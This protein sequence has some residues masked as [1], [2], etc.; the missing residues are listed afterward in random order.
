MDLQSFLNLGVVGY[1]PT[2]EGDTAKPAATDLTPYYT[3]V[4][5]DAG[6]Y[7]KTASDATK[8][9]QDTAIAAK[10]PLTG[11]TITGPVS[12]QFANAYVRIK[13]TNR[14]FYIQAQDSDGSIRIVDETAG[15]EMLKLTAGQQY[16]V[17]STYVTA[18]AND[19]A[20]AYANDRVANLQYRHVTLGSVSTV[21]NQ[22]TYAP[23]GALIVGGYQQLTSNAFT[24]LR[25]VYPQV[26]DPVRGW[27]GFAQAY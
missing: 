11:G 21:S 9:T 13:G 17:L 19:R 26:Y 10:L 20:L 22:F 2:F 6:F 18:V 23:G 14:S 25:Y 1:P 3:K 12:A 7:T 8:A 24:G 15:V 4:Q 5:V 16:G 27:V